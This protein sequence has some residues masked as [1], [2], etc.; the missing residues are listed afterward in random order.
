[1]SGELFVGMV[2]EYE[3]AVTAERTAQHLGSGTAAVFATPELVRLM[4]RAAVRA[5]DPFLP[6]GQH[7]VG[8][9]VD[10]RHLAAT[11]LGMQ[12][13]GRAELVHIDGRRVT[14]RVE[15][16]DEVEKIGEGTHQRMII[17]LKRFEERVNK[18]RN[19]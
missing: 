9:H 7:T 11:P 8:I 13:R 18:K 3:A 1:M 4:E 5:V 2:G 10:V 14:F 19:G 17:D 15:A 12:V 16:F 6:E